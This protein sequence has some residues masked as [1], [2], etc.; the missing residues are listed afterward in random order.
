MPSKWAVSPQQLSTRDLIFIQSAEH[1]VTWKWPLRDEL[2]FVEGL[3]WSVIVLGVHRLGVTLFSPHCAL[4]GIIL[5]PSDLLIY[6]W[7]GKAA[8]LTSILPMHS[9]VWHG[10]IPMM[11]SWQRGPNRMMPE[12]SELLPQ[13]CCKYAKQVQRCRHTEV[14]CIWDIF[15]LGLKGAY[16]EKSEVIIESVSPGLRGLLTKTLIALFVFTLPA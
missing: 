13:S 11:T 1:R 2:P 5:T 4:S 14:W 16:R 9:D 7:H 10:L 3:L 6:V 8:M 15:A 12:V